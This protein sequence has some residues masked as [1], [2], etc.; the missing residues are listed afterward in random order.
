[1]VNS[2][3]TGASLALRFIYEMKRKTGLAVKISSTFLKFEELISFQEFMG[4]DDP[5]SDS[6]TE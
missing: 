6:E 5:F 4:M 3:L 2:T 1:M